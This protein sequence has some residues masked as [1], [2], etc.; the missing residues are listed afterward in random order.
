MEFLFQLG[1]C[2]AVISL[3]GTFSIKG[4]RKLIAASLLAVGILLGIATY[5]N[6]IRQS[7]LNPSTEQSAEQQEQVSPPSPTPNP[8]WRRETLPSSNKAIFLEKSGTITLPKGKKRLF[9]SH[10]GDQDGDLSYVVMVGGE[11]YS[12]KGAGDF[13]LPE[14]LEG[15]VVVDLGRWGQPTYPGGL[16]AYQFYKTK[17]PFIELVE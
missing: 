13:L 11:P 1:L 2:L 15:Q 4:K 9:L 17:K 16:S 5:S 7:Q 12:A 10:M 3:V 8:D 14:A 6:D